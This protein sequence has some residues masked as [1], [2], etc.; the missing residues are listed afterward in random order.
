LLTPISCRAAIYAYNQPLP[1][2]TTQQVE[3]INENATG[4]NVGFFLVI[5]LGFSLASLAILLVMVSQ[6][7]VISSS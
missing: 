2:T 1:K 5:G 3:S 4:F 6:Q 7:R